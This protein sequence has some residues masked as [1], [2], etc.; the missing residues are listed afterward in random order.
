LVLIV[1]VLGR[2]CLGAPPTFSADLGRARSYKTARQFPQALQHLKGM[3]AK[4]KDPAQVKQMRLLRAECLLGAGKY[5]D[6]QAAAAKLQADYAKDKAILAAAML[7]AGDALRGLK[8]FDE[9]V[10]AYRKLAKE[11]PGDVVNASAALL[12]AGTT[13]CH[14]LK[15]VPEGLALYAE[16]ERRFAA[17]PPRAAAGAA[18]AAAIHEGLTRDYPK[19]AGCYLSLAEKYGKVYKVDERVGFYARAIACLQNAKN[20]PQA[21]A[22]AARAERASAT[23]AQKTG[24]AFQQ[25]DL[26]VMM[27]KFPQAR[28][29]CERI[30]CTWPVE[31]PTCQAAQT[32]IIAAWRAEKKLNET[33]GA[34][35]IFYNAAGG[36]ADIRAAAQA[37]A[38]AMRDVDGNVV[39]ANAFLSFQRHGPAGP[40]KRPGTPDDVRPNHL[41]AVRY[42]PPEPGRDQRFTRA[43]AAQPKTPDGHRARAYLY[44]HWGKTKEAAKSFR[45]AFQASPEPQVPQAVQELVMVGM[46]AHTASFHGLGRIFEFI[47][48]GPK[49]KSGK[50]KLPN[51]FAGL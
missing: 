13:Y 17:D 36:E 18:A 47:S 8:K 15:K 37:V 44:T 24:F 4:Y 12:R 39:R 11:H 31:L 50:E 32:R 5:A 43:L 6:A 1:L 34:A 10:A 35:R 38:V 19:A 40:D 28:A 41:A 26:L 2:A 33:L 48:Y 9:A 27:K 20:F 3:L 29:A 23:L 42:P 45:L 49:G 46:K 14:D 30:I 25:A 22:V 16:V 7:Y 21:Q 51:P